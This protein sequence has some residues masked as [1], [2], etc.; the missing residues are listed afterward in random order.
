MA[1]SVSESEIEA[2]LDNED[3]AA[4]RQLIRRELRREPK[5]HWLLAS[6]SNAY[7]EERRYKSA[8]RYAQEAHESAPWCPFAAWHYACALDATNQKSTAI[9]VWKK[10]LRRGAK[11]IAFGTC[12]EGLRWA[13]SLLN[14]SRYRIGYAYYKLG[15]MGLAHRYLREHLARRRRGLSTNYSKR[16]VLHDMKL[17]ESSRTK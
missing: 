16:E 7:Y 1:E 15:H 17:I 6:L 3:W 9:Q 5:H 14:D 13:E 11:R 2:L 10:L 8:L 4:A 12:G